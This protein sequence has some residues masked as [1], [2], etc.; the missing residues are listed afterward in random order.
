M[1]Y[2]IISPIPT[3]VYAAAPAF[4]DRGVAV[5]TSTLLLVWQLPANSDKISLLQPTAN[6]Q[7]LPDNSKVNV[8]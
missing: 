7:P 8:Y 2:M 4:A 3:Y 6:Q 1:K 5:S